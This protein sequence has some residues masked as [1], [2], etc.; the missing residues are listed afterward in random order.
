MLISSALLHPHT[1]SLW[2]THTMRMYISEGGGARDEE[3]GGT[4][5]GGRAEECLLQSLQV[6]VP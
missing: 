5:E 2:V 6:F 1:E 4:W 3:M